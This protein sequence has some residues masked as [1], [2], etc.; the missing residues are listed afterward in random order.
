MQMRKETVV[1]ESMVVDESTVVVCMT[2]PITRGLE[3]SNDTLEG[4]Q[5][6]AV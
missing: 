3:E 4:G 6:Q 5:L 1:G 2:A